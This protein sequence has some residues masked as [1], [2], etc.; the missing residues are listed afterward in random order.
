VLA[1]PRLWS[2]LVWQVAEVG[3]F[4]AIWAYLITMS[5]PQSPGGIGGGLYFTAVLARFGTVLLLSGL[6]TA[7]ILRPRRD[8]VRAGGQDDPAGGVLAGAPDVFVLRRAP[9]PLLN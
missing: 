6:V 8:V 7:D 9:A 1:R 5:S 3:Y 4:L 2:Y